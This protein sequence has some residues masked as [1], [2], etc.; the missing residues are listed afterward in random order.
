MNAKPGG[1]A[2]CEVFDGIISEVD[3]DYSMI[4]VADPDDG[5]PAGGVGKRGQKPVEVRAHFFLEIDPP[6]FKAGEQG[7]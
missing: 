3:S 2:V 6:S 4:M 5:Y 1:Y 7:V